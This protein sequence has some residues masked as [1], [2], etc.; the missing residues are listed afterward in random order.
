[1]RRA[2]DLVQLIEATDS[3]S[4]SLVRVSLAPTDPPA[5]AVVPVDRAALI[6]TQNTTAHIHTKFYCQF[7]P[8]TK[9]T[10]Q[11]FTLFITK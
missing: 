5:T 6:S 11:V 3:A 4:V 7:Q 9:I 10:I 8:T 1:M 2:P